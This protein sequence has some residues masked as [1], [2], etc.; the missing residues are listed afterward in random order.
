MKRFVILC[1]LSCSLHNLHAAIP[2][3]AASER[4]D[5]IQKRLDEGKSAAQLW[6]WGWLGGYAA[7]TGG[8]MAIYAATPADT[9]ENKTF[10]DILL[11]GAASSLLGVIGQIITPMTPAS[12]GDDLRVLPGGNPA[13]R[14]EKLKRAENFLKESAE[15]EEFGHSWLAHGACVVVNLGAG[16]IIWQGLNH[17]FSDGLINFGAGMLISEIQIFTQPMQAVRD[18]AEYRRRYGDAATA[19]MR[20]NSNWFLQYGLTNFRAGIYF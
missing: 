11:V 1:L 4:I 2:D 8:Q 18:Q 15:R 16:L 19:A 13:E 10:R 6:W 5:F 3:A 7:I 12:A 9:D 20:K 14:A 17:S